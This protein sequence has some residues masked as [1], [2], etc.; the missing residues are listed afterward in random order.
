M[1]SVFQRIGFMSGSKIFSVFLGVGCVAAGFVAGRQLG[2]S[3]KPTGQGTSRPTAASV[4]ENLKGV[5][6]PMAFAP[7][8]A[9]VA[10]TIAPDELE[11]QVR[12]LMADASAGI[13]SSAVHEVVARV[14]VADIP[15]LLAKLQTGSRQ[16]NWY[17]VLALLLGRWA[18]ADPTAAMKFA[19][20]LKI[21]HERTQAVA[22]VAE[23]WARRDL[24]SAFAF[25]EAMPEGEERNRFWQALLPVVAQQDPARALELA[26]TLAKKQNR[27]TANFSIFNT[28]SL[29]NP[30]AAAAQIS[31]LTPG[32]QRDNAVQ[33]LASRWAAKD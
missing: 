27:D 31:R 16:R 9:G 19:Q 21:S 32:Y 2:T 18:E 26:A 13:Y 6:K 28:W 17:G 15:A 3:P 5:S 11:A 29:E 1:G 14:A 7:V 12:R 8:P 23:A 10:P 22:L 20:A 4:V 30:A 25:A 24:P 33:N